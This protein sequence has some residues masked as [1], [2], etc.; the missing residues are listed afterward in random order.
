MTCYQAYK[1]FVANGRRYVD[2]RER[3]GRRLNCKLIGAVKTYLLDRKRLQQWAG[4][5][6][7]QRRFLL[8]RDMNVLVD[9]TTL[10]R[11]YIRN[12]VK[13]YAVSYIYNQAFKDPDERAE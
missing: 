7:Q 12:K 6:I 13:Y 1:R 5:S 10:V 8:E 9:P 4:Y 2:G 11:F 3:N